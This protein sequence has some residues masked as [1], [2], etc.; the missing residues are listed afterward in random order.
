MG[1]LAKLE[2]GVP[3]APSFSSAWVERQGIT[4]ALAK[5]ELGVPSGSWAWR[6][7]AVATA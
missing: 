2:L 6:S 5:L 1:A 7:V 4:G 3:G